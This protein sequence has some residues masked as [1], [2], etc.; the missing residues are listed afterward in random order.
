MTTYPFLSLSRSLYL[1]TVA[2]VRNTPRPL[3]LLL[4]LTIAAAPL[5]HEISRLFVKQ[6][7]TCPRFIALRARALRGV[8]HRLLFSL[9]HK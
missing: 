8:S 9:T 6:A 7:R 4:P 2:A 3:L 5:S 1:T